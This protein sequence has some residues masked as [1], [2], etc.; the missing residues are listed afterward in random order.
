MQS[1]ISNTC[2][3]TDL[4]T[5]THSKFNSFDQSH[6]KTLRAFGR[7]KIQVTFVSALAH[8][9]SNVFEMGTTCDDMYLERAVYL[10]LIWTLGQRAARCR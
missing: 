2:S 4:T 6:Q 7:H 8:D 10:G 5:R 1:E 9:R 3:T